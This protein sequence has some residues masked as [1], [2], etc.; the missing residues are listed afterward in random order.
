MK[1]EVRYHTLRPT[2]NVKRR[3]AYPV[4]YIPI[5]TIEC[6]GAHNPLGSDTLQ[7]EGLWCE[8][9]FF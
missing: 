8:K 4:A 9:I 7:A 6:H 5:G 2:Q 1:Q 3:Q